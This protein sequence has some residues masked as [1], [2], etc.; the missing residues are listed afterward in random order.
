MTVDT[1]GPLSGLPLEQVMEL[2]GKQ[3][4]AVEGAHANGVTEVSVINGDD[5]VTRIPVK[6]VVVWQAGKEEPTTLYY[7]VT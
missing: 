4:L 6:P 7:P 5:S 1:L 3:G 2:L